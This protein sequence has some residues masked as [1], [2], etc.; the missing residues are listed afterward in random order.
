MSSSSDDSDN[1]Y[2][3]DENILEGIESNEGSDTEDKDDK[4]IID[5]FNKA[6]NKLCSRSF[7][8]KIKNF[9][10]NNNRIM[11][12]F[13]YYLG[14]NYIL[15]SF[16]DKFKFK[17]NDITVHH[18]LNAIKYNS[19]DITNYVF[20]N[21]SGNIYDTSSEKKILKAM[22]K[23]LCVPVHILEKINYRGLLNLSDWY[24]DQK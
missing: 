17:K 21:N 1:F 11:I 13:Y 16:I 22:K 20:E 2:D 14:Q 8:Y 10:N 6:L 9:K 4:N 15:E 12:Q 23:N 19:L 24:Y 7:F 18:L 5:D 3:S